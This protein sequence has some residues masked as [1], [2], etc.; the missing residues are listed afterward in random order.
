VNA[1][2]VKAVQEALAPMAQKL[3][4]GAAHLYEVYVRQ[5]FA[6]GVVGLAAATFFTIV[7]GLVCWLVVPRALRK[8][9]AMKTKDYWS[10]YEVPMALGY[11]GLILSILVALFSVGGAAFSAMKVI[12]PE[13][14]AIE[15]ILDQIKGED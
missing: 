1:D 2:T 9:Y 14:Y 4:E 6:E 10:D 12:N 15:R 11:V 5:M 13:Y 8:G 3:G 7:C